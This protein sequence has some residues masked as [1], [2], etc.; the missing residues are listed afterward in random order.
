ME[1]G[2]ANGDSIE[3]LRGLQISPSDDEDEEEQKPEAITIDENDYDDEDDDDEDDEPEPIILGFLEKPKNRWSLLRQL[4]PSKAGGVP[5]WL[6]P[7]NLPSGRSCLCDFCGEPLQFLLQVYAPISDKESAFHRT[8]FVFMC[9]SMSCLLRDQHE[10]W[11]RH[12]KA[13]RSVKVFQS[14]LPHDNPFY[15]CE[16]PKHNGN[17]KPLGRGA[18]LCSWC[19]T[20]KG[21]KTCSRCKRAHYCSQKH[22]VL[23]W[24]RGHKSE[25]QG[26]SFSSLSSESESFSGGAGSSEILQ[27]ACNSLW[28]EFEMINEDE[29]EYDMEMLEDDGC[30]NSLIS[31]GGVDDTVKSL[32]DSFEGDG[33]RK[34]WASFQE[35]I[36]KAPEQVL[37]Y[38]R[39]ANAK[40]LWPMSSGRPS[41]ADIPKCS[42]CG[43]PLNF[44]FQILPQLL[45]YF[46]VKNE[47]DSLDWATIVIYTCEASCG[48]GVGYK[49]ELAWVQLSSPS[50]VP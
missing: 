44:E 30:A 29:S 15:S 45:Y 47:V 28:P 41:K 35:R 7:V 40:P 1:S 8:L 3:K 37:R 11:K 2:G 16:A 32:L 19:G 25:C 33:D 27:A 23:H 43:G 14:Q 9:P 46:D 5:A 39:H 26:L 20:W 4:F 50:L 17:D 36:A 12:E 42:F 31:R 22:Q 49:E 10:Q 13:S 21:D 24:R 34:S 38:C 18:T 6:D 48:D